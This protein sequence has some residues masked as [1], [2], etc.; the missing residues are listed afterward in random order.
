MNSGLSRIA[1][2]TA[3]LAALV[4][5]SAPAFTAENA[6][7]T[8]DSVSVRS[9]PSVSPLFGQVLGELTKGT[10][11]EVTFETDSLDTLDGY[12]APWYEIAYREQRG[13]VFG[14]YVKLDGGITV[15]IGYPIGVKDHSNRV[16]RFVRD[17]LTSFGTSQSYI[18]KRLGEP[19]SSTEREDIEA[20][21]TAINHTLTYDGIS[22]EIKGVNGEDGYPFSLTCTTGSYNFGGLKVGS[23]VADVKR[24][25]GEPDRV[26]GDRLTYSTILSAIHS[27]SFR[28]QN[29]KVTEITLSSRSYD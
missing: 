7:I 26:D 18:V 3:L 1:L 10:R 28:I 13:D 5:L 23:P 8:G 24:I 6:T 20:G 16:A 12:T 2:V 11:V 21:A 4:A 14:K 17:E 27:A 29:G 9:F 25:L 19:I 15:N 22:L